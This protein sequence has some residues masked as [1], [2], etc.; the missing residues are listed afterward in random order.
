LKKEIEED[1]ADGYEDEVA[2]RTRIWLSKVT[3]LLLLHPYRI[4]IYGYWI[5]IYPWISTHNLW[6]R[7]WMRNFIS[8]ATLPI[9]SLYCSYTISDRWNKRISTV[10]RMLRMTETSLGWHQVSRCVD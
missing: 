5:W 2:Y 6:I 8:T 9:T 7:I 10:L 1:G 3:K 4:G